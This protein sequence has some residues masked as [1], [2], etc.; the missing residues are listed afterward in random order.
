MN[1]RD[2][3]LEENPNKSYSVDWF[4][5]RIP[6][7]D[8]VLDHLKG[9][10]NLRLLEIGSFEGRSTSWFM[11]TILTHPSSSAH[12]IDPWEQ[13]H[14]LDQWTKDIYDAFEMSW[15]YD[16]FLSNTKEYG[17]RVSHWKGRSQELIRYL[18]LSA[19]LN[20]DIIYID[21]S[22]IATDAMEDIILSFQLLKLGG[23]MILDD[24]RWSPWNDLR[25]TPRLAVDAFLTIYQEK[26]Q[27][28]HKDY[29]VIIRRTR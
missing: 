9:K 29:Q 28:L 26:I 22:H 12:C 23:V 15:I 10:E 2:E 21:G 17:D 7:L 24:Y 13:C 5:D 19:E 18:P 11:D 8:E 3:H 1:I 20:Y 14:K 6:V 16:N 25:R 4:R 27:V